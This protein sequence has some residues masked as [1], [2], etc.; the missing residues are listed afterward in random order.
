VVEDLHVSGRVSLPIYISLNAE[1]ADDTEIA[2]SISIT[3]FPAYYG[4]SHTNSNSWEFETYIVGQYTFSY[5][6]TDSTGAYDT[7]TVY[8]EV[9]PSGTIYVKSNARGDCNGSSWYHAFTHPQDAIDA[10][11]D[12]D[13]ILVA[14][15][16]D[17]DGHGI[18]CLRESGENAVLS[19]KDGVVIWGGYNPNFFYG[20]FD[21]PINPDP[22]RDPERYITV[23]EGLC[24]ET[25]EHA[26]HVVI[27]AEGAV[28]DGFV[29]TG[30]RADGGGDDD[31]GGGLYFSGENM[32][33]ENW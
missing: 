10:A 1:D 32:T 22:E 15:S 17:D 31:Y 9:T 6:A 8:M 29:V 5:T 2:Y 23:I 18:Y 21:D 16:D 20:I 4:F 26:D 25:G 30:G 12:G 11:G 14:G 28:L 27:G 13:V 19:L 3:S 24:P 7:G 33:V